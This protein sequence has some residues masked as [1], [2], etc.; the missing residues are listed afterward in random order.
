MG[1]YSIKDSGEHR[2]FT[3]GAMR[4]KKEGKGRYDL[5]PPR[6]IHALAVH[7]QKGAQKYEDRNWEKGMPLGEFFDSGIRHAFQFLK[8]EEDENHLI[9]AIWNLVC[10]Y[11]TKCRIEEGLL[12]AEL[13]DLP[14]KKE[15]L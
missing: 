6:A 14:K 11:D 5:L 3:S 9:A 1:D 4:D 2:N 10:L 15:K 13:D 7:F 12:P 8:G